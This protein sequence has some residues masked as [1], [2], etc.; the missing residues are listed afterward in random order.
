MRNKILFVF[1]LTML[2]NISFAQVF[3]VKAY[4]AKGDGKTNDY[5]SILKAVDKLNKQGRGKLIFPKGVYYIDKFSS[6]NSEFSDI[7]FTNLTLLEIVGNNSKIVLN[8]KFH[9]GV[10][11]TKGNYSYSSSKTITPLSLLN[12]TNVTISDLEIDGGAK[13]STRDSKV[14][15]SGG[16]LLVFSNTH[17][18]ILNNLYLHHGLTDG[19]Y[20]SNNSSNIR[21]TNIN[22]SNNA[23]QG[24]SLIQGNKIHFR[25]SKFNSN[26]DTEGKYL[27]HNPMS[28]IDIEPSG[29]GGVSDISFIKCEFKGNLGSQV[30]ITKPNFTNNIRIQNSQISAGISQ[31]I[32]QLI[33][34]GRGVTIESNNIDCGKGSIYALWN[35]FPNSELYM[36]NN[37]ISSSGAGIVAVSKKTG[38]KVVIEKNT[39][40]YTGKDA[41]SKYFPYI[42]ADIEFN[43]NKIVI[44]K[45]RKNAVNSLIRSK[46][47]FNNTF[48]DGKKSFSPNVRVK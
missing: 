18:V 9:R 44:G 35:N 20:V 38:A 5:F 42:V 32:Y 34:A 25:N 22:S 4:G 45:L 23:R 36:Y 7:Q 1:L 6:K 2:Q 12:C 21:G 46:T 39:I 14:V 31:G 43:N 29:N 19:I 33:L 8:A 17:N 48:S 37:I 41:V 15:E 26:G 28:G 11:R 10:E 27:G 16:R 3:N 24:I 30:I 47:S 40:L 13:Y